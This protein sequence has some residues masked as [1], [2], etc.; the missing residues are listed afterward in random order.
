M[1]AFLPVDVFVFIKSELV[2]PG[3]KSNLHGW[4]IWNEWKLLAWYVN[5]LSVLVSQYLYSITDNWLVPVNSVQ[6]SQTLI[7]SQHAQLPGE[8]WFLLGYP[9]F[10]CFSIWLFGSE[11]VPGINI[12]KNILKNRP[13]NS[14]HM[15][16][17]QFYEYKEILK[18]NKGKSLWLWS[19][20]L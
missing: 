13:Y 14:T 20:I 17:W 10:Q 8:Y 16:G 6:L 5:L 2:Y 15:H 7:F 9:G 11:Y 18:N 12:N 4:N 3:L 19:H 1:N